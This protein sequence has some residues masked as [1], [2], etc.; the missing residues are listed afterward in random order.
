M[1]HLT[2]EE[3][4]VVER[5]LLRKLAPADAEQFEEHYLDCPDCLEKLELSKQLHRGLRDVAAEDGTSLTR[6]AALAWLVRRG[7]T[8][9][10]FLAVAV[11]AVAVLPWALLAPRVSRLTDE[12]QRLEGALAQALAPQ[13][14]TP[15]YVLS[16]E[17]SGTAAEP[18]TRVTLDATSEW[19]VLALQLPPSGSPAAS[20]VRL[21]EAEGRTLWESGPTEPDVSGRVTFSVHSSWLEAKSYVVELDRPATGGEFF[22]F[23]VQRDE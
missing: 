8:L 6:M 14:R 23:Q 22:A 17:R 2:I 16:P 4:N 19:V 12:Q 3:E 18:S 13:M 10:T 5:Y 15:T 7:R 21:R 11:L 9:Q 1:D 20:R